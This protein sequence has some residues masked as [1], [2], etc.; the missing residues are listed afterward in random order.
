MN[1]DEQLEHSSPD[2]M[3]ELEELTIED[4][5]SQANFYSPRGLQAR[6]SGVM[7]RYY[8]CCEESCNFKYFEDED[9]TTHNKIGKP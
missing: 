8:Y 5:I 1:A 4:K 9:A 6:P 3:S 7:R 2:S